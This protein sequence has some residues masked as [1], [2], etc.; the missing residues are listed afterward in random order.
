MDSK[1]GNKPGSAADRPAYVHSATTNCA[2]FLAEG[3]PCS[4]GR[5]CGAFEKPS[6]DGMPHKIGF[7][8]PKKASKP[9]RSPVPVV[10][11]KS[12]PADLPA[13]SKRAS[14][15]DDADLASRLANLNTSDVQP[16]VPR[17]GAEEAALAAG[18]QSDKVTASFLRHQKMSDD[19]LA[20]FTEMFGEFR[21]APA[22]FEVPHP[23]LAA[24]R[25]AYECR[26]R[27]GLPAE[28]HYLAIGDDLSRAL[29]FCRENPLVVY[30]SCNPVIDDRD[31]VRRAVNDSKYGD[32]EIKDDSNPRAGLS[33]CKHRVEDCPHWKRFGSSFS[34]DRIVAVHSLYYMAPSEIAYLLN[35]VMAARGWNNRTGRPN[36]LTLVSVAHNFQNPSELMGEATYRFVT[37][38]TGGEVYDRIVEM[39][40]EGESAPYRHPAMLWTRSCS[41]KC[42]EGK[43]TE[44][45]EF[46]GIESVIRLAWDVKRHRSLDVVTFMVPGVVDSKDDVEAVCP[47]WRDGEH[48]CLTNRWNYAKVVSCLLPPMKARVSSLPVVTRSAFGSTIENPV[49]P[50]PFFAEK[51]EL[52]IEID[53]DLVE[54]VAV[55]MAGRPRTG[56]VLQQAVVKAKQS[57]LARGLD[58]PNRARVIYGCAAMGFSR[59]VDY[60]SEILHGVVARQSSK[61]SAFSDLLSGKGWRDRI[62]WGDYVRRALMVVVV[63][64]VVTSTVMFWAPRRAPTLYDKHVAPVVAYLREENTVGQIA[65]GA[66]SFGMWFVSPAIEW[67]WPTPAPFYMRLASALERLGLWLLPGSVWLQARFGAQQV[68]GTFETLLA[69]LVDEIFAETFI[70]GVADV[71]FSLFHFRA[72]DA[73]FYVC[74]HCVLYA[75]R[76]KHGRL[77]SG[78]IHFAWNWVSVLP[79]LLLTLSPRPTDKILPLLEPRRSMTNALHYVPVST[80][81][82]C[83]NDWG[84]GPGPI[85]P[86]AKLSV[87]DEVRCVPSCGTRLYGI[88][89]I[90]LWPVVARSCWHSQLVAV[91]HRAICP[92]FWAED[93]ELEEEITQ[94]WNEAYGYAI[95]AGWFTLASPYIEHHVTGTGVYTQVAQYDHVRWIEHFPSANQRIARYRA[96][97]RLDHFGLDATTIPAQCFVKK[98]NQLK[99]GPDGI[100][101]FKPRLISGRSFEFAERMGRFLYPVGKHFAYTWNNYLCCERPSALRKVVPHP[102]GIECHQYTYASGMTPYQLGKWFDDAL[103]VCNHDCYVVDVDLTTMDCTNGR[104]P[105]TNI[106]EVW[107]KCFHAP[108]QFVSIIDDLEHR[109]GRTAFGIKFSVDYTM[110]SGDADTSSSNSAN[111]KVGPNATLMSLLGRCYSIGLG[112][113]QLILVAVDGRTE[114]EIADAVVAAVK[115]ADGVFRSYGYLSKTAAY[116]DYRDSTFCSGLMYPTG[117]SQ[118]RWAPKIGKIMAKVFWSIKPVSKPDS[119]VRAV[120][121]GLQPMC[122]HVPILRVL[123][124]RVLTLTA[125]V[126]PDFRGVERRV[127]HDKAQSDPPPVFNRARAAAFMYHRY[128]I[129]WPM[130][131]ELENLI[132]NV[133]SLPCVVESLVLDH[134]VEFDTR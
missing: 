12:V 132:N 49:L 17:D 30:H 50:A 39:T 116:R 111:I 28:A 21:S 66:W 78:V 42:F 16:S 88:G 94:R 118:H 90:S 117:E 95:S 37:G 72:L 107:V 121:L 9:S 22:L 74:F 128:G 52:P 1:S 113:D 65:R 53:E 4:K 124:S 105:M 10:P 101:A 86:G 48:L 85:R 25:A 29:A 81:D 8:K 130:V 35:G 2:Y 91:T 64:F 119:H 126:R 127:F 20:A 80:V 44:D 96:H 61:F 19:K 114:R 102:L 62:P 108:R 59:N 106:H 112:D 87:G 123:F 115:V 36:S 133:T 83:P 110:F 63:A 131:E 14:T 45:S 73:M 125:K 120:A 33:W 18:W 100:V 104:G 55:A 11:I 40:V 79:L 38:A 82:Y 70:P 67:L 71:L 41:S 54:D 58:V 97:D 26:L 122:V 5:W 60:E 23:Y 13:E 46:Y 24:T 51:A 77:V 75:I 69:T 15:G 31:V 89:S 56:D 103:E 47:H 129:E 92:I 3:K 6:L 27:S 93:R 43:V 99:L 134:I 109:S 68:I 76:R 34:P 32:F 57:A 7:N 98:E 84:V